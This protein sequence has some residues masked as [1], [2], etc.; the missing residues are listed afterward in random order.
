MN[1]VNRKKKPLDSEVNITNIKKQL[2]TS[3]DI[4]NKKQANNHELFIQLHLSTQWGHHQAGYSI[5]LKDVYI[6]HC[7]S[8]ISL[9]RN[10]FMYL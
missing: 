9:L 10:I 1:T 6:S 7:E 2:P 5:I 4:Q 8:I 3:R